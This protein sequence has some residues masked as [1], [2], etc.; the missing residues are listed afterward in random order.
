MTNPSFP[1][2]TTRIAKGKDVIG[3]DMLGLEGAAQ[4]YQQILI[5]GIISTTERARYYSFY[6]WVLYRFINSSSGNRLLRNFRGKYYKRHEVALILGAYSHHIDREPIRSLV[7]SGNNY[8]KVRT[9]WDDN[10]PVSLDVNYFQNKLGGFGQYYFTAMQALDIVRENEQPSWVYKV[11]SSFGEPLAKAFENSISKTTYYKNLT[12][13]G[14]LESLTHKDSTNYGKAACLCSE[15]LSKGDD[16][17]ILRDAFF[18][19]DQTGNTSHSRRRLSLAVTLDLVRGAKGKFDRDLMLRPALYLGEYAPN[20]PY[21]PTPELEDWVYRWRMVAVRHQY[22]FGLQAL[23]AAFILQLRESKDGMSLSEFMGWTEKSLG[24][25]YYTSSLSDY[26]NKCCKEV[27]LTANWQKYHTQ[28]SSACLQATEVDEYSLFLEAYVNYAKPD[29]LL[30]IG[31]QSLAQLYLRFLGEYQNPRKEWKEMAVRERLSLNTFFKFMED[32]LASEVSL[33]QWLQ[34]IYKEFILGQHEFMALQKL[35]YQNYDT[36][37]FYFREGR[38]YWPFRR[39]DY[40][41][42]PIR[43][44]GNR[45]R[46]ALSI[47][48]DLGLVEENNKNQMSLTNVGK[49]FLSH[50]VELRRHGN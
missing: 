42:E 39:T 50:V 45:L 37:K 1:Q 20:L 2:W 36:F 41:R 48:T 47:L 25:K 16:L 23:W 27:G 10:D 13:A 22:T 11:T 18:R 30:G 12:E 3:E 15:A 49:S 19:F 24:T 40:W 6:A 7:G 29:I 38:F 34:L 4:G 31:I 17:P 44:A 33:D 21:Q 46:N 43:L 28:F 26:L 9:W 14:E 5:P 8:N 35:R 32:N